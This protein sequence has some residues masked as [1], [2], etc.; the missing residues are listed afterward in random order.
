MSYGYI[1]RT[2]R[3]K[4]RKAKYMMPDNI[5][6]EP[7]EE[8]PTLV[9]STSKG[10]M[11]SEEELADFEPSE[12]VQTSGATEHQG[13]CTVMSLSTTFGYIAHPILSITIQ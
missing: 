5:L 11:H 2:F 9:H 4:R 3:L 10:F 8:M 6:K 12:H 7:I 13:E 1:D